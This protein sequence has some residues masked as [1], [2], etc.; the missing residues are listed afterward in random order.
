MVAAC[1]PDVAWPQ[2]K[3]NSASRCSLWASSSFFISSQGTVIPH[4]VNELAIFDG[5]GVAAEN[6]VR[7]NAD[8]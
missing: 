3:N 7:S 8:G 4:A 2:V 6:L 1:G 5:C